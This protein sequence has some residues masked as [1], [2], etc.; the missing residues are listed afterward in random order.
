MHGQQNIKVQLH[1]ALHVDERSTSHFSHYTPK[2]IASGAH[3]TE[4]YVGPTAS[5]NVLEKDLFPRQERKPVLSIPEPYH[6]T[7]WD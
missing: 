5:L 7:D 4:G 2:E 1:L 6:D 3:W